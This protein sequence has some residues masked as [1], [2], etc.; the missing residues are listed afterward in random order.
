MCSYFR[1][2]SLCF[3]SNFDL[4]S[5]L[6]AEL[7]SKS[8]EYQ[9]YILFTNPA[10]PKTRNTWKT[11]W[12]HFDEPSYPKNKKYLKNVMMTFFQVFL[13]F[14]VVGSLKS[15][16]SGYSLDV[17]F[18]P[19]PMSSC[20]RNLSKNKR[21]YVENTNKKVVFYDTYPQIYI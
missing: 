19:H 8:N 13:V 3:Y 1:H 15:M 7:N 20:Y 4:E 10:T 21:R 12:W 17:K 5:S 2:I 18:N 14:G 11:W 9:L 16:P 6:D